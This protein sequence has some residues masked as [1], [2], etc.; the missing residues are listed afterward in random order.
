[1]GED[2]KYKIKNESLEKLVYSIFDKQDVQRMIAEQIEKGCYW[3]IF[4]SSDAFTTKLKREHKYLENKRASVSFS[5]KEKDIEK[6]PEYDPKGWNPFPVVRPP[7]AK[8]YLVQIDDP[9]KHGPIT[10]VKNWTF[11][12]T[13]KKLGVVAFRELPSPYKTPEPKKD[14]TW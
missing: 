4:S 11:S 3:I 7:E 8:R 6:I 9:K 2:M 1:M 12:Q 5:I 10:L 14:E 13:W